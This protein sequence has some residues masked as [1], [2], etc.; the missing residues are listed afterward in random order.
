MLNFTQTPTYEIIE[1][2]QKNVA[3]LA[4]KECIEF[5]VLNPDI[6]TSTYSGNLVEIDAKHYI[7]RG[8]KTYVDLAHQLH[9]R[10]LTPLL[11]K[12]ESFVVIRYEKL[13]SDDSFHLKIVDKEQKYGKDSIFSKIYKNEESGFLHY[14]KQALENIGLNKRKRILNLGV[15]NADE[16]E[17]IKKLSTNFEELELVGIDYCASAIQSAKEKFK[18]YENVTFLCEDI[19]NLNALDLG[20][21]DLIVSVG[22]LQSSNLEYQALLLS[23]VQNQLKK[24]GAIILGFPN[25]RW[26]DGEMIY[27]AKV[28]NYAFSELGLLYK[29]VVFAK[30][31]LQQKKFRV[32]VSGKDYI[33]VSA[34]SIRKSTV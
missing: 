2:L 33:F 25:C 13:N 3:K 11:Y 4:P 17:I 19:N 26:V 32:M 21:F 24:D 5:L 14:Y 10:M 30:K 9:C 12:E 18:E 29:D 1:S 20:E 34:T 15:N 8:Y 6:V 27:G 22:T 23:I 7:Y 31:Y 16:F 28:K